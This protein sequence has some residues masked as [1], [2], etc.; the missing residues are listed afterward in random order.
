MR[1]CYLADGRYIH[2]HRWLRFFKEHGHEMSLLSFAPM[3]PEH[4]AA[5]EEAGGK[6]YGELGP[7]HLKR[8]WR[9]AGDL[10]RLLGFLRR[11]RIDV[12][13]CHF[14]GVNAWYAALSRFHPLV[15]TVMGGDV[16]GPDWKPQGS[17]R[18]RL[19]TPLALRRADLITCWSN[20]LT[21]VVRPFSAPGTP[22]EVIHGGVDLK[23]FSPGPKPQYLQE[24]WGIP[25]GAK[26]VLSPR[27]MRPL[28]NLDKIA[29]A[30]TRVCAALPNAYFLFAYLSEAKDAAY[31]AKVH[32]IVND[33]LATERIRFIGAI[34]HQEMADHYRLAD[35][36]ISIPSTDGT[37]MSVLEAMACSTPVVV[38]DIPDYDPHYI[39]PGET[40]LA[41]KADE[42]EALAGA[43]L[44]LMED[45]AFAERL[46]A[47]ARRRVEATAS[48][49]AQMSR[50]EQLYQGLLN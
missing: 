1:I 7:F 38:S 12:L 29:M 44:R 47:E 15:I 31:E 30:A 40:V 49:Q 24:R 43:L 23:R 14:L 32:A 48:Y 34:P 22:I 16:C 8:F 25:A 37:P 35:M 26:V 3:Q 21:E 6:Y 50:M 28:Y 18:E 11:E 36:V 27:L 33:S 2:A 20:Q 17:L 41:A 5:V 4:I 46:A 39:E 19:L 13:H 45:Q 42:I 10:R 9:T